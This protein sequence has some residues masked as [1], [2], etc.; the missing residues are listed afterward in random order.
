MDGV[1]T[2][3]DGG[4]ADIYYSIQGKMDPKEKEEAA[5]QLYTKAG[6]QF[7]EEL[8]WEQG[9]KEL[10]EAS[11]NLFEQVGILSSAS[12]KSI[13]R[14]EEV[15][16]GKIAWLK[17]HMPELPE[18]SIIIVASK[19]QKQNYSNK[20]SILVDDKAATIQQWNARGGYGILHKASQYRRT[21]EELEDIARPISLAEIV[22]RL[23][24][25][26]L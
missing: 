25:R 14:L 4:F 8:D 20:F 13:E 1:L 15:T 5:R 6:A 2:D 3:F 16:D 17:K 10:W 24:K 23:K 7:W 26:Y 11:A 22:K 12:A 19:D 18:D 21:I 9:G